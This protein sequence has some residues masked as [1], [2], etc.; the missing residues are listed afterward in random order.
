MRREQNVGALERALRIMGGGAAAIIAAGFI[1]VG[2]ANLLIGLALVALM[3][4]GIDFF[5]TG[6]TGYCP[7]Y[8]RLGWSTVRHESHAV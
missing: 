8:H 2:P 7:L 3:L 6:V 1:I 5:V 4:I